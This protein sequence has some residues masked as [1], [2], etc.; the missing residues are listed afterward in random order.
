M[1]LLRVE[2]I[3]LLASEF[4]EG[5]RLVS[6]LTPERGVM[7]A[8]ARGARRP[9]S[10][11]GPHLIPFAHSRL[12]L[13]EGKGLSG[14]SQAE[15]ISARPRLRSDLRLFGEAALG[16]EVIL[17]CLPE[18]VPSHLPFR[19]FL[20]YLELLEGAGNFSLL[21][22]W[23]CQFLL[24]LLHA[25][26]HRPEFR[27]CLGCGRP[28]GEGRFLP[29]EG[30][31]YCSPCSRG[32]GFPFPPPAG[33][34]GVRLLSA[35]AAEERSGAE[36]DLFFLERAVMSSVENILGRPLRAEAFLG[37]IERDKEG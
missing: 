7:R 12:L 3:V 19:L 29:A 24:K 2:A 9:T 17:A 25:L 28:P 18:G 15:V 20:R 16:A 23:R 11:L 1:P 32:R 35:P 10:R 36:E 30:G 26:G 5:D 14:I 22:L 34:L 27:Y 37:I 31:V 8:V 21:P 4:G 13:W 33:E 6:F